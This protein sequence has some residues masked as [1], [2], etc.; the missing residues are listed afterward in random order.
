MPA[1]MQNGMSKNV[2]VDTDIYQVTWH[3]IQNIYSSVALP[4]M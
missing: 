3:N 4:Y 1:I 2:P